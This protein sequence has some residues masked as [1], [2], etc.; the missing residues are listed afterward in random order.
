MLGVE[1]DWLVVVKGWKG[2]CL[3]STAVAD[4]A[5]LNWRQ[6]YIAIITG[7]DGLRVM[8][9]KNYSKSDSWRGTEYIQYTTDRYL[10]KL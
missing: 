9:Q 6:A 8:K 3:V 7:F 2:C 4:K 10:S 5:Y 1:G